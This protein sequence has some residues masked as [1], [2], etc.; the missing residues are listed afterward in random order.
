M[1]FLGLIDLAGK[2][3]LL[4]AIV[5]VTQF[6]YARLMMPSAPATTGKSF[7][8]DLSKSM[9]LQMRYLFPIVLGVI[10]YATNGIIA[11]YFIVSNLFG[12]LQELVVRAQVKK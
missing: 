8:D 9:H 11:L 3:V 4:A 10:A 7:Q 2:S 12:I 1:V 5:V 6:L